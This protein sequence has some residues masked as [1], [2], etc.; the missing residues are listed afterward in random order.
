[1]FFA[2]GRSSSL[3]TD[4]LYNLIILSWERVHKVML[5][6]FFLFTGHFS[7]GLKRLVSS[8]LDTF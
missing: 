4:L 6:F 5:E 8:V 1:M 7:V 3:S 2:G